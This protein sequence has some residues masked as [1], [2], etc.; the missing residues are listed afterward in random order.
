MAAKRGTKVNVQFAGTF[1]EGVAP[2]EVQVP[3]D[4]SVDVVYV[5]PKGASGLSG[6]PVPLVVSDI[7]EIVEQEPN[8]E[9]AKAN[10]LTVPCGVTGPSWP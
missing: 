9:P 10:R 7:D 4:P 1:V 6:W 3:T 2:V 5:T 8:N